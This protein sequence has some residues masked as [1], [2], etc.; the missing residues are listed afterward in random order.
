MTLTRRNILSTLLALLACTAIHAVP[1]KRG[2]QR[3]LTL[4]DGSTVS[5]QLVGDEFGHYWAAADGKA[6][7]MI[8]DDTHYTEVQPQAVSSRALAR[9]SAANARR[10]AR[11][12][13]QRAAGTRYHGE[14][15]GIIILVSFTNTAFKTSADYMRRV[16]NEE[17]FSDGRFR[18]SMYDYFNAQ[19]EGQFQLTF[20][21]VGP[22][23]V[24]EKSSYY[25]A[26]DSEGNDK[27]AATMVIEALK[28]A[29][30][31]VNFADYDWDGDGEVD[32]VYVIYA[33]KGEADGG[34]ANTIWPHEWMLS[35]AKEYGDGTGV[36]TLDGVRIDT[37]ACGGE[38]NG[39]SG[40]LAGIGTM[41]HEFSHCLGYP[42][43]YDI[44]YSGGQG[45][46]DW[47]L[48]DDGSYN[49]DGYLPAGYTGYE[50]WV[51]GWKEPIVLEKDTE[52]EAMM[53]LQDGGDTYIIYNGGNSN[54]YYMLENRQKTG[55]D[56]GIPGEGLLIVHVDYQRRA[57]A[58]NTVNDTPSHQRMTWVAADNNYQYTTYSGT[59]YYSFSGAANDPFPYGRVNA[60]NS[61]T[62]PAATFY[63]KNSDGTYFMDS[64][65]EDIRRNADGTVAFT[66]KAA[67][68][69]KPPVS[70]GSNRFKMLT[71]T[72][73]M[74]SGMRCIIACGSNESAAGRL[75]G[76]TYLSSVEVLI[77]GD[78]IFANSDV[79][80]FIAQQQ[81]TGGWTLLNE[82]TNE[83]LYAYSA[84]KLGYSS[85]PFTWS[86]EQ[87]T[88]GVIVKADG[89]GTMLYNV[90]SP[91]FNTYTSSPTKSMIQACV[92]MVYDSDI[93]TIISSDMTRIATQSNNVYTID[94]RR[95]GATPAKK[96]VYIVNGK[97]AVF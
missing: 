19:S 64:S 33:G 76:D 41:C 91:R 40:Q 31:D 81:P 21:V 16:A 28:L 75:V 70:G 58:E 51:A 60:F 12:A 68:T 38:L 79:A 35:E 83:Y 88:N 39:S 62:T 73:D 48:M 77:N 72:E 30:D 44:D 26:N 65:V 53:S 20:D 84:K 86:L 61:T 27:Y 13:P 50:R 24:S 89:K 36:Q 85:T 10:S 74:T 71:T 90:N 57:W 66:F 6:Y 87:G 22:Y 82:D 92:Y 56:A 45:M 4:S 63:N 97:K 49:E 15:K 54:E 96:G 95:L 59:R 43:F 9:R 78:V 23:T 14:K 3:T 55:W 11:M 18:G 17:N 46:F 93:S 32:Q 1:A 69:V 29:D 94:G 34:A 37:Y 80:V 2:V 25:G 7:Q 42:D 5:A 47:D 8:G 67:S 52:V